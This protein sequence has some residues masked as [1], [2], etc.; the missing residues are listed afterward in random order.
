MNIEVTPTIK[1]KFKP[2]DTI[3]KSS[4]TN[5]IAAYFKENLWDSSDKDLI[6]MVY[7]RYSRPA[8]ELFLICKSE[9]EA[10]NAIMW[11]SRNFGE[12]KLSWSMETVIKYLPE[13]LAKH[14]KS[15]KVRAL[16]ERLK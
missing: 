3:P 8:K 1:L 2:S 9:E 14:K 11:A 5:I 4:L 12:K 6:N 16:E 13:Y 10:I 15:D 7:K